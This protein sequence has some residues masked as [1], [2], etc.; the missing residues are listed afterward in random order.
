MADKLLP[1]GYQQLDGSLVAAVGLALPT[2]KN[3]NGYTRGAQAVLLGCEVANVRWTDDGVTTPTSTKGTLMRTTDPP[4]WYAGNL[5]NLLF[6]EAGAG[7][8][9]NVLYYAI[10]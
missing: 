10:E 2:P 9:L 6:I 3:I 8:L 1:L 7:A 5:G 4:F